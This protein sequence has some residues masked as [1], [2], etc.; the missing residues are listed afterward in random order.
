MIDANQ[1]QIEHRVHCDTMSMPEFSEVTPSVP[2]DLFEHRVFEDI[3]HG[4]EAFWVCYDVY[5][6]NLVLDSELNEPQFPA[7]V[8]E[9]TSFAVEVDWGFGLDGGLLQEGFD[10]VVERIQLSLSVAVDI[11]EFGFLGRGQRNHS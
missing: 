6:V 4:L 1:L 2:N 5:K 9:I 8:P 3:F 10:V 7:D 11:R